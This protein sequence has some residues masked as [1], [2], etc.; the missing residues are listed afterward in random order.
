M[1]HLLLLGSILRLTL[2]S[3]SYAATIPARISQSAGQADLGLSLITELLPIYKQAISNLSWPGEQLQATVP[4]PPAPFSFPSKTFPG[5]SLHIRSYEP[6]RL[7]T[8]KMYALMWMCVDEIDKLIPVPPW[9]P[10]PEETIIFRPLRRTTPATYREDIE[11]AIFNSPEE[12]GATFGPK[13]LLY[14][15][16][17]ILNMVFTG[18]QQVLAATVAHYLE[19]HLVDVNEG[20]IYKKVKVQRRTDRRNTATT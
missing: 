19:A 13:Q 10:L 6:E 7:T 2:I 11:I 15:L 12:T 3:T 16:N 17:I 9:H 20:R 5:W 8:N 14:L 4:W 1:H 18:D